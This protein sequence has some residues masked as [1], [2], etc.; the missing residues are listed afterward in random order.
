MKLRLLGQRNILGGGIL[1]SNMVDALSSVY[2]PENIVEEVDLFDETQ[3]DSAARTTSAQDINVW[4]WPDPRVELFKGTQIVWAM[5]E[6]D[7]LPAHY[8]RFLNADVDIVWVPSCWGRDVLIANGVAPERIDIVPLGV[9]ANAFHSYL[10]S[11]SGPSRPFRFLAVGKFEKRKGYG[12]LLQGFTDA[13]G[14]SPDVQLVIKADYFLDLDNKK[15]ALTEMVATFGSSNVTIMDG[16]WSREQLVGLYSCCDA[17][18]F[19]SRS[20][21]WGLPA[22]EAVAAGLPIISTF[23]S[24]HTEFLQ[25]VESSFIKISAT[26]Q[27]IDDPEYQR[28]WPSENGDYGRWALPSIASIAEGLTATRQLY[29]KLADSALKNSLLARERFSWNAAANKALDHL[30]RRGMIRQAFKFPG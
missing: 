12:E 20:E 30:K 29:S 15:K 9:N 22:I 26:L 4:T 2:F 18:V 7:R 28:Y 16:N 10:R 1:F 5:F 11:S 14:N 21:A 17:F 6:S 24:G 8:L 13:F 19:P 25:H 3:L 27:P 23:Y